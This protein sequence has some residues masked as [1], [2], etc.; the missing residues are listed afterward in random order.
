M[1]NLNF[2]QKEQLKEIGAYLYQN[3]QNQGRSLERIATAIY[4]RPT[5]LKAIEDGESTLLPEP[6]F[7]QGFIRR[8]GDALGLDGLTLS[9]GFSIDSAPA[10]SAPESSENLESV[11]PPIPQPAVMLDFAKAALKAPMVQKNLQKIRE[12]GSAYLSYG[13]M[14][15]VAIIGVGFLASLI[16]RSESASVNLEVEEPAA[17]F[18]GSSSP[19]PAPFD[20]EDEVVSPLTET[21]ISE[22]LSA[23]IAN[24]LPSLTDSPITVAVD[25]TDNCWMRVTVDG[26]ILFEGLL[27]EGAQR[28]WQ[29][30][31]EITIRVGNAGAVLLSLNGASAQPVGAMHTVIELT[32]TPTSTPEE[33]AL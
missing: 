31:E 12:S 6:V 24:A 9:R 25:L 1:A 8:Y 11:L 23:E 10:F 30:Q 21:V 33:I 5:L 14:A 26:Q 13:A 28:T 16:G 2:S 20:A 22:P 29:A 18:A 17:E 27:T 19:S 4:I 15:I 3:R 7:I 32:F